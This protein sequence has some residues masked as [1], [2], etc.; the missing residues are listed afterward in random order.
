MSH[1][2]MRIVLTGPPYDE[3]RYYGKI[4]W[5]LRDVYVRHPGGGKDS[6]HSDGATRL[7]STDESRICEMRVA[8]SDVIHETV[9]FVQLP[10]SVSEPAP[11]RDAIKPTDLVLDTSSVGTAPRLAV[12]IAANNILPEVLNAWQTTSGVSSVQ[13]CVDKGLGQSLIVAAASTG[14][15]LRHS[16]EIAP[17][18]V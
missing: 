18:S 2:E 13:T 11:L 7:T 16:I 6:R 9:N 12:E 3:P 15:V 5:G 17:R 14:A 8:T 4:Q 10:S 1:S